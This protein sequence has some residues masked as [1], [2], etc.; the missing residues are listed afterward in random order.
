MSNSFL[1]NNFRH[2]PFSRHWLRHTAYGCVMA[3]MTVY[4]VIVTAQNVTGGGKQG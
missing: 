4:P 3:A 1:Q 2:V